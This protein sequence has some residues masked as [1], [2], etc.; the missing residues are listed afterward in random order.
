MGSVAHRSEQ[1][2]NRTAAGLSPASTDTMSS[3]QPK[4]FVMTR[5]AC[6]VSVGLALSAHSSMSS[7]SSSSI[8]V[9]ALMGGGVEE[10][11][12]L[13]GRSDE[14]ASMGNCCTRNTPTCWW[15]PR[16]PVRIP[17]FLSHHTLVDCASALVGQSTCWS[18]GGV[19]CGQLR[20]IRAAAISRSR[21]SS[22]GRCPY[23]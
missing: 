8:T 23:S 21:F 12:D 18:L 19:W 16:A 17:P 4:D 5:S 20:R 14:A 22:G 15:F 2:Y 10:N 13:T 7:C 1:Q 6:S 3:K 9:L 11:E